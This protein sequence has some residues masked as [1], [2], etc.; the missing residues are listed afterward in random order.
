MNIENCVV[1]QL[2]SFLAVSAAVIATP[3]QDTALTIRNTLVGGRSAGISTAIGV[4]LGQAV[5]AFSTALGLVA[6]L[7][8]AG[9]VFEVL[10]LA[11]AGYL[12]FLG[13]QSIYAAFRPATPGQRDVD[14]AGGS[15]GAQAALRQGIF[16]NL[17]NPKMAVFFA[18]LLPQFTPTAEPGFV[19]LA[20]LGIVFCIMTFF[21]LT[22]YA[23]IVSRAG[24]VLRRPKVRRFLEGVTGAAL[25]ALGV[26]V[27]TAD[28]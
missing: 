12:I 21:W 13:L 11:G 2:L 24:D 16:S 27:A 14:R 23:C 1:E 22:A 4:S 17:A 7:V 19:D 6:L 25:V 26:R 15:S 20:A 8:A 18:S 5:W 3:G 9:P 28:S 10:K